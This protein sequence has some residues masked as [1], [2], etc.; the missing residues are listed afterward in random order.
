MTVY[1]DQTSDTGNR[2]TGSECIGQF[3]L[4]T[5]RHQYGRDSKVNINI[6]LKTAITKLIL[7]Q[8]ACHL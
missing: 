6:P 1:L 7:S 4:S 8:N 3:S 5:L 2:E